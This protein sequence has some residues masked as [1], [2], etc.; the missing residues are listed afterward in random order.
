MYNPL[1]GYWLCHLQVFK[2]ARNIGEK[3]SDGRGQVCMWSS[4]PLWSMEWGVQIY[5][6]PWPLVLFYS[7]ELFIL[8]IN[9][10]QIKIKIMPHKYRC[11]PHNSCLIYLNT[12]I[13][14]KSHFF[15]TNTS[16][17]TSVGLKS[18]STTNSCH[19][20]ISQHFFNYSHFLFTL[21]EN[22]NK[23]FFPQK[24][25]EVHCQT[26]I[27]LHLKGT[28]T[29]FGMA[30]PHSVYSLKIHIQGIYLLTNWVSSKISKLIITWDAS[31]NQ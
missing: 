12:C 10:Y 19:M 23:R 4:K 3:C 20:S 27:L 2:H 29:I 24:S 9:W 1:L 31:Y 18:I 14:Y 17:N 8:V 28:E 11:L 26:R 21:R 16:V 5:K 15:N 30:Y 25:V 6:A 7:I 22:E 13:N